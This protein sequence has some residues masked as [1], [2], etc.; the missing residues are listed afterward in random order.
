[1]AGPA[2]E[3]LEAPEAAPVLGLLELRRPGVGRGEQAP[4]PGADSPQPAVELGRRDA[5]AQVE[6]A[7]VEPDP[8]DR[9]PVERLELAPPW[10]APSQS[11][12]SGS[13]TPLDFFR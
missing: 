13:A 6:L 10:R 3:R 2:Q 9:A 4:A 1:V 12:S 8:V 7:R 11:T 5:D